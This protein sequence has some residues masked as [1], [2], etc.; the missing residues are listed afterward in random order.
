MCEH[1]QA[2]FHVEFDVLARKQ[3]VL[4][5]FLPEAPFQMLQIFDEVILLYVYFYTSSLLV[6]TVI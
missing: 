1:N 2:S 4:A 6:Y 5:Y 3:Q